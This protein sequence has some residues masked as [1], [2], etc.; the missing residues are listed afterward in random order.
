MIKIALASLLVAHT[1]FQVPYTLE[2][3]A[4]TLALFSVIYYYTAWGLFVGL[5]EAHLLVEKEDL[6]DSTA[7]TL[8]HLAAAVVLFM[9]GYEWLVMFILPWLALA[10]CTLVFTLLIFFEIIAIHDEKD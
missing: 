2:I 8:V 3:V 6:K 9:S 10:F 7:S 5:S 1:M 4:A